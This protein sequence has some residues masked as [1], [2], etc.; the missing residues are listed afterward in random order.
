MCTREVLIWSDS[1]CGAHG[2]RRMGTHGAS[3]WDWRTL[4]REPLGRQQTQQTAKAWL[5]GCS[6]MQ[7]DDLGCGA[8]CCKE[9]SVDGRSDR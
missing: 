8:S 2:S 5:H 3:V 1:L 4:V 9:V 6:P 7:A